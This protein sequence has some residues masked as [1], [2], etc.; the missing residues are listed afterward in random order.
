MLSVI[1]FVALANVALATVSTSHYEVPPESLLHWSCDRIPNGEWTSHFCINGQPHIY[2]TVDNGNDNGNVYS[3]SAANA[4]AQAL[5]DEF[6]RLAAIHALEDEPISEAMAILTMRDE[7]RVSLED[8]RLFSPA[9]TPTENDET[10]DVSVVADIPVS[11]HYNHEACDALPSCQLSD[12]DGEENNRPCDPTCCKN[13]NC[14]CSKSVE[15]GGCA[16]CDCEKIYQVSYH[17]KS[18]TGGHLFNTYNKGRCWRTSVEKEETSDSRTIFHKLH[19]ELPL[20][21]CVGQQ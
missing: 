13:D 20:E 9:A 5:R 4:K 16:H 19:T 1:T 10:S 11:P 2:D 6:D 3:E 7:D 15:E 12:V 17:A 21:D 18:A 8:L 14:A